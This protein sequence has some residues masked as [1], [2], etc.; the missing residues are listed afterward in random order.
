MVT[1]PGVWNVAFLPIATAVVIFGVYWLYPADLPLGLGTLYQI[2][3]GIIAEWALVGAALVRKH[4]WRW[5]AGI[6]MLVITAG[7]NLLIAGTAAI[8]FLY[9]VDWQITIEP[10][11]AI[12]LIG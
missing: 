9:F 2:N 11:T 1:A 8:E 10:S 7:C 12:L 4:H 3:L 6:S 5:Y